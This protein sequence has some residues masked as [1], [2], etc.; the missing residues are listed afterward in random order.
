MNGVKAFFYTFLAVVFTSLA[1][2]LT[3]YLFIIALPAII[4]A[5]IANFISIV[6]KAKF[7]LPTY[8]FLSKFSFK[9]PK[10]EVRKPKFFAAFTDHLP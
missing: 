7:L 6:L 3:Y 9:S 1:I 4:V 8:N 2:L 5:L 10:I